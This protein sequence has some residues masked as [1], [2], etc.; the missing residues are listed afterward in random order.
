MEDGFEDELMMPGKLVF[1]FPGQ[2]SFAPD[3][4]RKMYDTRA[5]LR[6]L[7]YAVDQA[8]GDILG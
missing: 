4:L 3:L 6:P 1:T 2:G 8:S 7:F 5:G